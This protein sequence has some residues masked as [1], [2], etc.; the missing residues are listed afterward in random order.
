MTQSYQQSFVNQVS[1][2]RLKLMKFNLTSFLSCV[3]LVDDEPEHDATTDQYD[4]HATAATQHS[5]PIHESTGKTKPASCAEIF[6]FLPFKM[7]QMNQ[8]GA[9]PQQQNIPA[10]QMNINNNQSPQVAMNASNSAPTSQNCIR[11]GC[12][13]P[14]IVSNDWE[15]EYC[16]NECVIT[17]CRDVF[18]NWVQNQAVAQQQQNFSAVN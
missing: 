10:Q 13:N 6:I 5:E 16:S 2:F 15:D 7:H 11:N 17:H 4:E 18:G 14:A 3:I 9:T 1:E 12:T 8:S